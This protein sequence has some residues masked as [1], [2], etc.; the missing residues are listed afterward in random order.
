MKTISK[1]EFR[2]MY[3]DQAAASFTTPEE[4]AAY[5]RVYQ[6]FKR[7]GKAVFASAKAGLNQAQSGLEQSA[8]DKTGN[9]IN[10]FE[11][12][13]KLGAGLANT[14]LSP[15]APAMDAT[16]GKG[17][18]YVADNISNSKAV[19]DFSNTTAGSVTSRIAENTGNL[20]TIAGT[21]G[22]LM[23][24]PNVPGKIKTAATNAGTAA[25]EVITNATDKA[26]TAASAVKN[27]AADVIPTKARIVNEQVAKAFDLNSGDVTKIAKATGNDVGDF[28]ARNKLIGDTVEATKTNL[29]TFFKQNYDTVRAEIAKV[30]TAYKPSQLPRYTDA[31]KQI[32]SQVEGVKGLEKTAV[33]V[34]NLLA[35]KND[36]SL[37]DVQRVKEL[38]DEH[39][40]LYKATGDVAE[41]ATKEGLANIRSE[42]Q[43]FIEK[44]VKE[45]TGADIRKLNNNVSTSKSI[46]SAIENRASKG[47]TR[48][49]LTLGDL[50]LFGGAS[51]VGTPL[52]GAA[53]VFGKKL[54]E[55]PSMRLKIARYISKLDEASQLKIK[56]SLE[57][58]KVPAVIKKKF[59]SPFADAEKNLIAK[60][61]DPKKAKIMARQG[62]YID[63][64]NPMADELGKKINELN[65]RYVEKPTP[66]NKKALALAK[67]RYYDALKKQSGKK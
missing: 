20:A 40:N 41:G 37:L 44:Q 6:G 12:V 36:I 29:D 65:K 35:K 31:L 66:A 64:F 33:E 18:N 2:A 51:A 50:S 5:Q 19:Q 58:G 63:F 13:G 32:K 16:V 24:A 34:D 59:F 56:T 11:G 52:L 54:I 46:L 53:L 28:V 48:Q 60:G 43:T 62:G 8:Y 38:L 4:E 3:G 55:S 30:D 10:L 39:F 23:E 17:L 47:L 57:A 45:K 49:H 15:I 26:S 67:Q 21:V 42:I 22:G 25:G 9:P 14:V 61:I 7:Y 1:E 27:A